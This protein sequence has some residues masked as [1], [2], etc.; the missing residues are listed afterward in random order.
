MIFSFF[1]IP[2]F[3]SLFVFFFNKKNNSFFTIPFF[4]SL[5][6]FFFILDFLLKT[7]GNYLEMMSSTSL[8]FLVIALFIP[9]LFSCHQKSRRKD[10][11]NNYLNLFLLFGFLLI[12]FISE[13]YLFFFLFFEISV[14]PI[15]FILLIRGRSKGKKEARTFLFGFTSFRAFFFL[16]IL[17]FFSKEGLNLIFWESWTTSPIE[18]F[19][20]FSRRNLK[21]GF[22]FKNLNFFI[23]FLV[24]LRFFVKMPV[25]FFHMWLPKAHVEAPVFGSIVLARVMLKLGGQGIIIMSDFFWN[26]KFLRFFIPF[27]LFTS[28][29]A[30]LICYGQKDLKVLIALSRVNHITF[31]AR[32]IISLQSQSIWGSLLLMLGHGII[33]SLIF[34]SRAFSYS[35]TSR[36]RIFFSKSFFRN[37]LVV[38]VWLFLIFVNRGFPPFLNFLG[39]FLILKTFC[40]EQ[41]L[42]ILGFLNFLIVGLYG[43]LILRTLR[44]GKLIK[45]SLSSSNSGGIGE[46]FFVLITWGHLLALFFLNFLPVLWN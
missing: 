17:F 45:S 19:W 33:S 28:F 8:G 6:V 36:R 37:Y 25:F 13:S 12:V 38:L 40:V 1:T 7:G 27:F 43:V 14:L 41:F 15:I 24:F 35:K 44:S 29:L 46:W 10:L 34:F 32:G 26:W 4:F 16:V 18:G 21:E 23:S 2:F 30:G 31:V 5:F 9:T 11:K 20:K 22:F 42:T 39:E 3:F